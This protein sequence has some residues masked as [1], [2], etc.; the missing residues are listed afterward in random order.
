MLHSLG[1]AA[2]SIWNSLL[3]CLHSFFFSH[4]LKMFGSGFVQFANF[5]N[6]GWFNNLSSHLNDIFTSFDFHQHISFPTDDKRHLLDLFIV[7][8]NSTISSK[9]SMK[10]ITFISLFAF[11]HKLSPS[12]KTVKFLPW[13]KLDLIINLNY[14]PILQRL[15]PN[16]W[17]C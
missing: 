14:L 1:V 16:C 7:R 10:L 4:G 9:I 8:S 6:A 12:Y 5:C 2:D 15:L 17:H 3:H 11:P 13:S